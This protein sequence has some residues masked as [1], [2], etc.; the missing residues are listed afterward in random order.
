MKNCY[1]AGTVYEQRDHGNKDKNLFFFFF[2]YVDN[3]TEMDWSSTVKGL[4]KDWFSAND[5][6]AEIL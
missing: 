2:N 6:T 5:Q 4:F 3:F 1:H